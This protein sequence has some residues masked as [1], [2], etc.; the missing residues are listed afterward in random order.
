MDEQES[1]REPCIRRW[2]ELKAAVKAEA[3]GSKPQNP[4]FT[5]SAKDSCDMRVTNRRN[6]KEVF[7]RYDPAVP[8]IHVERE[9]GGETLGFKNIDNVEECDLLYGGLPATVETIS[10]NLIRRLW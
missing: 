6:G 1:P 7:L 2:E 4:M 10:V 9:A 5:E 8:C 3:E